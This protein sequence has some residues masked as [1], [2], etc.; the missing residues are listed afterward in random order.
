MS[1]GSSA[2]I[3]V[4]IGEE[5]FKTWYEG[6]IER[7]HLYRNNLAYLRDYRLKIPKK[8]RYSTFFDELNYYLNFEAQPFRYEI[9]EIYPEFPNLQI[10]SPLEAFE[11]IVC[12]AYMSCKLPLETVTV[13]L[14]D[15]SCFLLNYK[16]LNGKL[17]EIWRDRWDY[18]LKKQ[19]LIEDE[20]P[21]YDDAFRCSEAEIRDFFKSPIT[22]RLERQV[23]VNYLSPFDKN[24]EHIDLRRK[25]ITLL[26]PEIKK[27]KNLKILNLNGNRMNTL[28]KELFELEQLVELDLGSNKLK[29]LP[30]EIA[31]LKNLKKLNVSFMTL[32]HL[33]NELTE[34]SNLTELNASSNE[35]VS[36]P[37]NIGKLKKLEIFGA[38]DNKI[39]LL[40]ESF[41]ELTSLREFIMIRAELEKLPENIGHLSSLEILRFERNRIASLPDSFSQLKK[42]KEL[43]LTST[44]NIDFNEFPR[45]LL[46]LT[47][48]NKLSFGF[49][50]SYTHLPDDIHRMKSLRKLNLHCS[51]ELEALPDS[52]CELR[53]MEELNVE[54]TALR[55]LPEQIG[56]LKKLKTL[57]IDQ[58]HI[59]KLPESI[60]ELTGLEM[61]TDKGILKMKGPE[62]KAYFEKI[63]ESREE[64]KEVVAD[65]GN[66]F[67]FCSEELRSDPEFIRWFDEK[68]HSSTGYDG[69]ALYYMSDRLKNDKA[70]A[71]EFIT[72]R[73]VYNFKYFSEAVRSDFEIVKTALF[74]SEKASLDIFEYLPEKLK[75]DEEFLGRLFQITTRIYAKFPENMR[76]KM[77]YLMEAIKYGP[78]NVC[79]VPEEFRMNKDIMVYALKGYWFNDSYD[80]IPLA[81][82]QDRW[83]VVR[84]IIQFDLDE[85]ESEI[86]T[87]YQN[88]EFINQLLPLPLKE[89]I[90][91]VREY[92]KKHSPDVNINEVIVLEK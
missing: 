46:E 11:L 87:M 75:Q 53:E 2:Y 15:A 68:T 60:L 6:N 90:K 38:S 63:I 36:L 55:S 1:W 19:V 56:K 82:K 84:A 4:Y 26:L 37:E 22:K 77:E 65:M 72:E 80:F 71:L 86:K 52:F 47:E 88:D 43:D 78:Y 8:I 21:S 49:A 59:L 13:K 39:H 70:F 66:V 67:K 24:C 48:L 64:L 30:P 25:N 83:F 76:R 51:K 3:N 16:L 57:N 73:S 61:Q 28:P 58:T 18:N 79:N 5:S 92:F 50:C 44:S 7:Q 62:T 20:S 85:L 12:M 89:K 54:S 45:V 42:V 29:A 69:D 41:C 91:K 10:E 31:K 81:L 27:F 9:S 17:I 33:P 14:G 74:D 40:P 35:L 34:L 23:E 32:K